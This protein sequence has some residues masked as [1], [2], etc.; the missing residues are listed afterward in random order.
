MQENLCAVVIFQLS[1]RH[2]LNKKSLCPAEN[3]DT[4]SFVL[5]PIPYGLRV[6]PLPYGGNIAP[7]PN[8]K[9]LQMLDE[10]QNQYKCDRCGLKFW[11]TRI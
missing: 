7:P 11:I 5:N 4:P 10:A 6:H 8:Q 9:R 3:S 1:L 2:R